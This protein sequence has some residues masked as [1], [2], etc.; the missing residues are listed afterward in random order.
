M[1]TFQP[2]RRAL[3]LTG[4]GVSSL[5]G[6]SEPRVASAQSKVG[7]EYRVLATTKTSTLKKK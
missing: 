1:P 4:L 7:F 5:M 3:T 6:A 2:T